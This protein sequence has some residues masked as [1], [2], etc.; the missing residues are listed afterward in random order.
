VG[1]NKVKK[2]HKFQLLLEKNYKVNLFYK[3]TM[4]NDDVFYYAEL[5]N[6]IMMVF[7]ALEENIISI[8]NIIPITQSYINTFYEELLIFFTE[9]DQFTIIISAIG[10]TTNIASICTKLNIPM[11]DDA[12]FTPVPK[13]LYQY[14]KNAHSDTLSM[15]GAYIVAVNEVPII[16]TKVHEEPNIIDIKVDKY[17]EIIPPEPVEI[18]KSPI[19]TLVDFLLSKGYDCAIKERDV[20]TGHHIIDLQKANMMLDVLQHIDDKMTI[21]ITNHNS[22][23][24]IVNGYELLR[25]LSLYTDHVLYIMGTNDKS[26]ETIIRAYSLPCIN[27]TYTLSESNLGKIYKIN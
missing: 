10:G 23:S 3:P 13:R 14:I 12:K 8:L 18:T 24:I 21:T 1:N 2:R 16:E 4:Q 19:D 9:Q 15:Y 7:R 26:I 5:D 17:E 20:T 22:T 6:K 25:T 11:V 27:N